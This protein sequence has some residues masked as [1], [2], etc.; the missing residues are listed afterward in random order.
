M[1]EELESANRRARAAAERCEQLER[2][3]RELLE[4][5]KAVVHSFQM[6]TYEDGDKRHV[7]WNPGADLNVTCGAQKALDL[8]FA[9]IAKVEGK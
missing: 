4:A 2:E 8:A 5:L 9:A 7:G 3:S 6:A 1:S